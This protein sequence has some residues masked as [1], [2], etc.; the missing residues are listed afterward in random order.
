MGGINERLASSVIVMA[1]TE[2]GTWLLRVEPGL[3]SGP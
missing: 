2:V 1:P 3:L